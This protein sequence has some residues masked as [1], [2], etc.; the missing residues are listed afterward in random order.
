M[1]INISELNDLRMYARGVLERSDHHARKVK[2]T[3]ATCLGF[4]IAFGDNLR[5][6]ETTD[7][8]SGNICWVDI[9]KRTYA[10]AYNHQTQKVEVRERNQQGN[11]L[12]MADDETPQ[13]TLLARLMKLVP[14]KQ[15]NAKRQP[16]DETQAAYA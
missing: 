8:K 16:P 7:P 15:S 5:K 2:G 3:V 6:R 14:T 12:I 10:F 13:K 9:G 11:V 1:P 4:V